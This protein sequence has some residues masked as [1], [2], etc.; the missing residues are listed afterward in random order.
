MI[1][2]FVNNT[3][4]E[5]EID[6]LVEFRKFLSQFNKKRQ[7]NKVKDKDRKSGKEWDEMMA[8]ALR[9]PHPED[10]RDRSHPD[11]IPKWTEEELDDMIGIA[12]DDPNR[13][14][15]L[16]RRREKMKAKLEKA[17]EIL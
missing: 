12:E 9:P 2:E 10:G 3:I 15:K 6:M 4:A 8:V 7:Q 17:K 16:Q 11:Y 1:E 5:L 14:E 13:E